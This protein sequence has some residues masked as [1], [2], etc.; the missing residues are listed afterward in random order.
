MTDS[1]LERTRE[2]LASGDLKQA[3]GSLR[4][5]VWSTSDPAVLG[6]MLTDAEALRLRVADDKKLSRMMEGIV[7]DLGRRVQEYERHRSALDATT[8]RRALPD[9]PPAEPM[10][11]AA[12][13]LDAQL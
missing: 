5:A 1:S 7:R 8:K 3:V 9:P 4:N 12:T 6:E 11:A 2:L 13:G 10:P